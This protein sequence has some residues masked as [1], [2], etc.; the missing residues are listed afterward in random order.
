M[1]II[2]K[3]L[4]LFFLMRPILFIPV[5][6]FAYIG[7]FS[8]VKTD[9]FFRTLFVQ[10][11]NFLRSFILFS[12][13]SLSV[14]AVNI[15]NQIID[16][17]VDSKNEGFPLLVKSNISIKQASIFAAIISLLSIIIPIIMGDY[18][19]AVGSF[20]AIL[21]GLFY[22]LK[23]FYF[24]GRPFMDFVS[25]A[26][27]FGVV[28]FG[29]GWVV[30]G[31][32]VDGF[33]K[34][35][36]AYFL[37]MSAGSISSTLPDIKGDRAEG[38]ITT[39]VFFGINR[40]HLIATLLI[41]LALIYSFTISDMLAV[42]SAVVSLPIYLLYIL[43]KRESFM[44]ATYKVGGGFLMVLIGLVYPYFLIPSIVVSLL[45]VIYF[46]VRFHVS[47]PSLMPTTES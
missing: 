39:A 9:S 35:S 37:L 42:T 2:I 4:D 38:K 20:L 16:Y 18:F 6:G 19:V 31:G 5:W 26:L 40:A 32:G 45:T 3:L 7:F 30:N 44:E 12:M 14:G 34:S 1:K 43:I 41:V 13:F 15:L 8:S 21:I 28:A 11:E 10:P 29:V 23:P 22:C 46:R 47:Y 24:T 27:G 17:E 33:V 36:F 25:N